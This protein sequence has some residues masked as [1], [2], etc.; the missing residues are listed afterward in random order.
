M[1]F[2]G[3]YDILA[4]LGPAT[5]EA[6]LRRTLQAAGATR[7][8]L[9]TSHLTVEAVRRWLEALACDGRPAVVLDLQG[10][11]WRLG[12]LKRQELATGQEVDLVLCGDGQGS[13]GSAGAGPGAGG[14][15]PVPH[16]DFFTAAGESDG[17]ILLNDARV[18]LRLESLDAAAGSARARVITGGPVDRAKG[19][20]LPET[21]YRRESLSR[22]DRE[23]TEFARG[24]EGI[25]LALSYVRDG[26]EMAVYRRAMGAGI[27]LTAKVERPTA[28][29]EIERIAALCDEVWLCR[30]DLG[31]EV[32]LAAMAGA[33]SEVAGKIPALGVPVLMAGQVLEHMSTS[34]QP[35]RAEV[36]Q[37]HDLL[38][39]GF[40]G[41]VLS[42]ET[43][44][45][46]YPVEAVR[47]AALFREGV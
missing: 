34:S 40:A 31:A 6:E 2:P 32:G 41:V 4:T 18:E 9:N 39:D 11:K 46:R 16:P 27:R 38:V 33:V 19:I 29:A 43:A 15:L 17:R 8:R 30:G 21:A 10:S 14:T 25:E 22:K 37:L 45:G 47:A 20:T 1:S 28:V 23:I 13:T 36:V 44:V 12:E 3:T 5:A 35:T 7:F 42:D 26:A 24:A